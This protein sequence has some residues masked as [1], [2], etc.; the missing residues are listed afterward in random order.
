MPLPILSLQNAA[1]A[2]RSGEAV[3]Y[4]TETFYGL[5]VRPDS[6]DA[7]ARLMALKGRDHGKPVSL[8]FA[9]VE[10]LSTYV[11]SLAPSVARLISLAWPGPLTI[12]LPAQPEVSEIITGGTGTVAVRVPSHLD[13]RLLAEAVGGTIT[14]TSANRQGQPPPQTVH[15]VARQFP[16]GLSGAFSGEE[17]TGG[18][19]STLVIPSGRRLQVLRRGAISL[20]TL[21]GWWRGDVSD[22]AA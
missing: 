9:R 5:G 13:A 14:A 22:L 20:D 19:P 17:T 3:A 11:R 8:I 12:V 6:D 7:L 21:R 15:E 16:E 4:P 1:D 18:A 2:V 10:H